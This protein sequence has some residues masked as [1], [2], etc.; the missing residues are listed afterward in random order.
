MMKECFSYLLVLSISCEV[1]QFIKCPLKV[2]YTVSRICIEETMGRQ[3]SFLNLTQLEVVLVNGLNK[4][5][6]LFPMTLCTLIIWD[7]DEGTP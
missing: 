1:T 6:R 2:Q 4:G 5:P 3:I 7:L